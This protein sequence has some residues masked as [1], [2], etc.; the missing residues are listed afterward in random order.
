[1]LC[2]NAQ[3]EQEYWLQRW[4]DN[5]TGWHLP[6]VHPLLEQ[7]FHRF[8]LQQGDQ[9]FVPFCGK[10]LDMA[11]LAQQGMQVIGNELSGRAIEQFFNAQRLEPEQTVRNGMIC[12]QAGPFTFYE[13]DFF[14][15]QPV[16]GE[17]KFIYDRAALISLPKE[18]ERGRKAYVKKMRMLFPAGVQTLLITLDY[19]QQIMNGPPFSVGYEEVV[20]QYAYDHVI[21]FLFEGDILDQEPKFRERGLSKLTEWGIKLTRYDPAYAAFS[22]SPQDF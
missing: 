14:D 20:W 11:W 12:W 1:M 19:D 6:N 3:M 7:Y 5:R 10:S 17:V 13:G 15:M 9:V 4:E 8:N 21:E 22:D 18:G 16:P 2:L